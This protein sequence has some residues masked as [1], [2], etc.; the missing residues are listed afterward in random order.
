MKTKLVVR[1]GTI[2][3]NFDEKSFFSNIPRSNPHWAY[4]H[5]NEYISQ[6]VINL[7]TIDK[8]HSK[9]DC[10]DWRFLNGLREPV[11]FSFSLDKLAGYK[12]FCMPETMH[13]KE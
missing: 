5:Y 4:K 13:F 2:A 8:I 11:L 9:C 12:V 7:S 6:K 3:I 10:I 1:P